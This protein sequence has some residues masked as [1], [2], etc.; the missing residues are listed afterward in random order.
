MPSITNISIQG[1]RYKVRVPY[2]SFLYTN[3]NTNTTYSI[4][5]EI[6][7]YIEL[8]DMLRK[9]RNTSLK[10]ISTSVVVVTSIELTTKLP[11][12]GRSSE[13]YHNFTDQVVTPFIRKVL[14]PE[15]V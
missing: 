7:V 1:T 4:E 3:T 10:A 15:G 11:S 2:P 14:K 12:E 6:Y 5:I 8:E 13:L 9:I